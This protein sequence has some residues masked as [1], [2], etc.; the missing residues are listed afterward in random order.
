[1]KKVFFILS[2]VASVMVFAQCNILGKSTINIA[3]TETYTVENDNAQC[4]DCHLWVTIG[5][6]T[7]IEGDFRKNK[8][9]IQPI[10]GGRTVL[11]LS[12]L[13]SQGISQC[14]KNIDVIDRNITESRAN[15]QNQTDCDIT[16]SGFKEVKYA[17]GVVSFFPN[18]MQNNYKYTWTVV[19]GD[20]TQKTS[21]EK[22]P[23]FEYNREIGI[24]TVR[25]KMMSSK[26]IKDLS[27]TYDVGFWK[28]F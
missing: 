27:K 4:P 5:G 10:A 28:F 16:I 13:T 9:T 8:V 20:G 11:S 24:S 1:M 2:L 23:Q 25:V 21:N 15:V 12:M 18:E 6:N 3:D 14:S 26:C 7:K 17:D 22:V 19:Y